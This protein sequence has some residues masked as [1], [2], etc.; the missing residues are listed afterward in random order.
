MLLLGFLWFLVIVTE[1]VNGA[2]PLLKGLGTVLWASFVFYFS[3]R[4]AIVSNRV[5]VLKRNWLFVLAM[6]VPVLRFVPH[7]QSYP[8]ARALALRHSRLYLVDSSS[9]S[10]EASLPARRMR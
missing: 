9:R 3:L 5:T 4:L 1:R 7:L 8:W 10:P 2:G 6:L